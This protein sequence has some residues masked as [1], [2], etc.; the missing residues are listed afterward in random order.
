MIDNYNKEDLRIDLMAIQKAQQ[1]RIVKRLQDTLINTIY[2]LYV[3]PILHKYVVSQS[4]PNYKSI[5]TYQA[6]RSRFEGVEKGQLCSL[7][8][9][10]YRKEMINNNMLQRYVN[11]LISI[12]DEERLEK[13]TELKEKTRKKGKIQ[14]AWEAQT[15]KK[16][17]SLLMIANYE[18]PSLQTF[19]QMWDYVYPDNPL[20]VNKPGRKSKSNP[21][22]EGSDEEECYEGDEEDQQLEINQ[23]NSNILLNQDTKPASQIKINKNKQNNVIDQSLQNL[24]SQIY[25]E[26][27]LNLNQENE[28]MIVCEEQ[29]IVN[30]IPQQAIQGQKD[31]SQ[32]NQIQFNE[33]NSDICLICCSDAQKQQQSHQLSQQQ[34]EESDDFCLECLQNNFNQSIN[35]NQF[36]I[37]K[38]LGQS[39][40]YPNQSDQQGYST[41]DQLKENSKTQ[42]NILNNQIIDNNPTK[43]IAQ[44]QTKEIQNQKNE[45]KFQAKDLFSVQQADQKY[46]IITNELTINS[47]NNFGDVKNYSVNQK[48]RILQ[49]DQEDY[50]QLYNVNHQNLQEKNSNKFLQLDKTESSKIQQAINNYPFELPLE[51]TDSNIKQ[52]KFEILQNIK[53]DISDK[54][55]RT[56]SSQDIVDVKQENIYSSNQE[57]HISSNELTFKNLNSIQQISTEKKLSEEQ[58]LQTLGKIQTNQLNTAF[59]NTENQIKQFQQHLNNISQ[60]T[61]EKLCYSYQQINHKQSQGEEFIKD[62]NSTQGCS[63]CDNINPAS[64]STKKDSINNQLQ[65]SWKKN[66]LL[67]QNP[68]KNNLNQ[69]YEL[70]QEDNMKFNKQNNQNIEPE[71]PQFIQQ[72]SKCPHTSQKMNG[73]Q[74]AKSQQTINQYFND[75]IQQLEQVILKQ[76]QDYSKSLEIQEQLRAEN[77]VFRRCFE[78]Q[79]INQNQLLGLLKNQQQ[80]V[81]TELNLQMQQQIAMNEQ[82]QLLQQQK[83][84]QTIQQQGQIYQQ[85][86]QIQNIPQY[87]Q[88]KLHLISQP[89]QTVNFNQLFQGDEPQNYFQ[90]LKQMSIQ[91][92]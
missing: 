91:Q 22:Q 49:K 13:P 47:K 72:Q 2:R 24:K 55:M 17:I 71:K 54:S 80:S 76:K 26:K 27:Y 87:Q 44:L 78:S 34:I 63:C 36:L 50:Q 4:N 74:I 42:L 45:I 82:Q 38:T 1:I 65:K 35:N 69:Q 64:P 53:K 7:V 85:K 41:Y 25:Q 83:Q 23:L 81:Q 10:E 60:K 21:N 56:Y 66:L 79:I 16:I 57:S 6:I 92:F 73:F 51:S 67:H 90:K 18:N 29:Q 61:N 37:N 11:T 68:E 3:D 62:T 5:T 88:E 52:Q 46:Q 86:S 89:H 28:K 75:K 14:A 31:T 15:W 9:Q 33:Q 84:Q 12:L 77:T 19:R 39:D 43:L 8:I 30:S 20:L 58:L 32:Q 70:K 40:D 48:N 59:L